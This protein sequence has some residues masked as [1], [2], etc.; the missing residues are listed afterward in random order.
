MDFDVP[1]LAIKMYCNRVNFKHYVRRSALQTVATFLQIQKCEKPVSLRRL[2][3]Q[4]TAF[5][6]QK[7]ES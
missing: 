2:H 3:K 1:N 7:T 6:S 5:L 4:Y